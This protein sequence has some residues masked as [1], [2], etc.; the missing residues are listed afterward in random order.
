MALTGRQVRTTSQVG[1]LNSPRCALWRRN[2]QTW[3]PLRSRKLT[4]SQVVSF[5][6]EMTNRNFKSPSGIFAVNTWRTRPMKCLPSKRFRRQIT[7]AGGFFQ[8]RL[9]KAARETQSP[10]HVHASCRDFS[11]SDLKTPSSSERFEKLPPVNRLSRPSSL[12][13]LDVSSPFVRQK[14]GEKRVVLV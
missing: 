6:R 3:V 14:T 1:R 8:N 9:P 2:S 13:K 10:C 12:F 4:K 11:S 5:S 7:K